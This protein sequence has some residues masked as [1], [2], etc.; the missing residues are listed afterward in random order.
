[1]VREES[2]CI[3]R[4]AIINALEHSG[5]LYIEVEITYDPGQF[6]LRI[7]DDGRGI[8]PAILEKGGRDNHWGLAGMRNR[9]TRVGGQLE[10]W[11]RPGAGTEVALMVP[12]A[13]AYRGL[14]APLK[15]SWIQ[16]FSGV[17][18]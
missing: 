16:R 15:S 4:E 1:M 11:S 13:T 14:H 18:R 5:H 9:A 7:R 12:G 2:Y 10:V 8:D 17:K 6:R 3:G